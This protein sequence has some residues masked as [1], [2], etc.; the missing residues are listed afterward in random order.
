[1]MILQTHLDAAGRNQKK[2]APEPGCLFLWQLFVLDGAYA[3]QG[4]MEFFS[5]SYP[6]RN[7][8]RSPA[9]TSSKEV[10]A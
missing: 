6:C 4:L 1:M 3:P 9:Y 8:G 2:E 7:P 10:N 5:A